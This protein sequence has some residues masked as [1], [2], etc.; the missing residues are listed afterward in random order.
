[1]GDDPTTPTA[2]GCVESLVGFALNGSVNGTE[3]EQ[4]PESARINTEEYSSVKNWRHRVAWSS[5]IENIGQF[6]T[7]PPHCGNVP[8]LR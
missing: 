7:I 1:M 6:P 4:R 3:L 8:D 5:P 2:E